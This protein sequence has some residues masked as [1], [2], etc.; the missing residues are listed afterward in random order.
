MNSLATNSKRPDFNGSPRKPIVKGWMAGLSWFAFLLMG[1]STNTLGQASNSD[2]QRIK[3]AETNWLLTGLDLSLDGKHL[4]TSTKE[5]TPLKIIDWKERKIASQFNGGNWATGSKVNIS[6]KG[7]YILLQEQGYYMIPQNRQRSIGF[8]I[9]EFATGKQIKLFEKVQDV[10]ISADEKMAVSLD[11]GEVSIWNL[12]DATKVSSFQVPMAGNAIELTPDG[13]TIIV[14]HSFSKEDFKG[15][16]KYDKQKKAIKF[17]VKY[18]QGISFYDAKTFRKIDTVT[19]LYD[20]IYNIKFSPDGS[21]L[22]VFQ[23]PDLKAQTS[24]KG[25]TYINLVNV[26]SR[27][28]LRLGFTSQSIAQPELKFSHDGKLFAI[29]SKGN[30]FQE[31]H[32]YSLED[33]TLLKRF[34]LGYRLFEKSDGEKFINDSRPSFLFLPGDQSILIAMGNR[35]I[36]WNTESNQQ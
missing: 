30:R 15:N 31:I 35:M 14:S 21:V 23:N 18:K 5:E 8:E 25:I 6:C 7:T 10:V 28:P 32:L 33:G 22:F 24:K 27:E 19:E 36:S 26:E 12:P 11:N 17:A 9:V 3:I 4:I 34:E 16:K 20:I 2:F 13:K 29:N 1:F